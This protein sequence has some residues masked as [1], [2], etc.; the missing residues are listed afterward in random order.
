MSTQTPSNDPIQSVV[1]RLSRPHRSGDAVISARAILAEG[2]DSTAIF[3]WIVAHA[4]NRRPRHHQREVSTDPLSRGADEPCV[5]RYT[6]FL[7]G[8]RR[9]RTFEG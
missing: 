5:D 9:I 8:G 4:G 7:S 2:G 6:E 1:T 3:D